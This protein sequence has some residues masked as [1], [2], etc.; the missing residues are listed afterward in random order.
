MILDKTISVERLIK[1]HDNNDKESYQPNLA[2]Q[3]V[4]CNIQPAS[5]EQVAL[6]DGVFAQA[7]FGFLSQ[8][9][10]LT[11]DKVTISGTGEVF[12]VKGIENWAMTD[13][14]PHYEMTLLRFEDEE[15]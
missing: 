7:Y 9:G 14:I 8:S 4:R 1:D 15:L 6:V 10:I 13:I 3:A 11:G 5:A 2:L 12:R